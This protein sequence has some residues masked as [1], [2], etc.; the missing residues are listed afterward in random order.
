MERKTSY[1]WLYGRIQMFHRQIDGDFFNDSVISSMKFLVK[2]E[3][4]WPGQKTSTWHLGFSIA[5]LGKCDDYPCIMV[6]SNCC[7][8][9]MEVDLRQYLESRHF[10]TRVKKY[11]AGHQFRGQFARQAKYRF[12][13][14]SLLFGVN[15]FQLQLEA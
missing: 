9:H 8:R 7:R 12:G 1:I 4:S 14:V 13:W 2:R 11:R 15:A 5:D 10:M 3:N 6:Q